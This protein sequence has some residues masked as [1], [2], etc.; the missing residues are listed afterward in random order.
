MTNRN[1]KSLMK[2][3][4]LLVFTLVTTFGFSQ[5]KWTLQECV[6]HALENN[7]NVRQSENNIL[8]NDQDVIAAKGNF[9]PNI[10]D[11]ALKWIFARGNRTG[12]SAYQFFKDYCAKKRIK[13]S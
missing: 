13:I 10:Q 9:L 2:N 8:I 1:Q 11:L 6:T 12:R 3:I 7:I 5:K 4:V